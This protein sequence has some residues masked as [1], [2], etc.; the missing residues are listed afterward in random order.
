MF[1]IK[2]SCE[3]PDLLN[4]ISR[5]EQPHEPKYIEILMDWLQIDGL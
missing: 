2:V 4:I 5:I 3:L 1:F